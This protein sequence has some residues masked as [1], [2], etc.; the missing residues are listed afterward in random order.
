MIAEELKKIAGEI[1]NDAETLEKYSRDASLFEIKPEVVVFP[2]DA[3]DVKKLVAFVGK[4]KKKNKNLSLTPRAGGSDMTGGPLTESIVVDFN[5]RRL[6]RCR[7]R[8]FL[9]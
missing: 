3:E 1:A 2:K 7:T 5:R 6:R 8:R 4:N 9:P